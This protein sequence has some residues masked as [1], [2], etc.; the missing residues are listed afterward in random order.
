MPEQISVIFGLLQRRYIPNTSVDTIFIKFII[1][2]R[3][4]WRCGHAKIWAFKRSSPTFLDH[5]VYTGVPAGKEEADR[6]SQGD[7]ARS[8]TSV[9]GS[10]GRRPTGGEVD[11]ATREQARPSATTVWHRLLRLIDLQSR[12]QNRSNYYYYDYYVLH[13]FNGPC[14]GPL[15]WAGTTKVTRKLYYRR[16]YCAMWRQK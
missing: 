3:A 8:Q 15:G 5:P 1:H 12:V 10:Q 4:F 11:E 14:T 2:V 9:A 7:V 16:D 6:V 13:P